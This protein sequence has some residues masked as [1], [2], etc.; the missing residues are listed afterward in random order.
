MAQPDVKIRLTADDKTRAAFASANSNLQ[1]L[2][3]GAA[4]LTSTFGA[5]GLA[6]SVG[7]LAAFAKSGIDAADALNDMSQRLGVSVKDL[8]S[9]KLIAEQSGTSLESVGTGIARLSKSIGEAEGGNKK[10]AQALQQLGITAR[11]PKE[12]FFQL[13]DAVQ[14]TEDPN[15]RAALLSAVLGKSY[16]ELV[17][18][19]NQGSD[20]LRESA[21]QSET[22]SEAMARLAP[23]A[24][25][26]NDELER[27]KTEGA[28]A[29]AVLLERIVPGLSDTAEA[30]RKLLDEDK[31]IQALVRAFAGLGKLPFDALIGN[32]FKIAETAP[33]R[34]KELRAELNDLQ[35]DLKSA[36]PG[37]D[38]SSVVMR[39]LFGT[40]EE[41]QREIAIKKNQIEALEKFGEQVYKPKAADKPA[42]GV[43]NTDFSN[44]FAGKTKA[45]AKLDEI[46]PFSSQ[47]LAAMKAEAAERQKIS[48]F[49]IGQ[50]E[51]ENDAIFKQSDALVEAQR[52]LVDMIDPSAKLVRQLTELDK[53]DGVLDPELLAAARLEINGQIDALNDMAPAID[54]NNDMARELGLTFE[55]AFENAI[56][57]GKK[58]SDVLKGLAQ[59]ILRIIARKA[60]TEPLGNAVGDWASGL[61]KSAN[62]NVFSNAPA[63][64]A[65]SGTVQTS[66][67]IF[68]FANGGVPNWGIGAEAGAE[69]ILPLKRG[70]DGKLGVSADGGGGSVVMHNYYTIDARGAD[71]GVEQRIRRAMDQAVEIA[72]SQVQNL[73]QR[74]QLRLT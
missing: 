66:P 39:K 31:G 36:Q 45:A 32:P 9:F 3:S 43:G 14:K 30:V 11:D 35:G 47:R 26:F 2:Q 51:A 4:K 63:L 53:F 10:L 61:F 74:G 17:P 6:V 7:G 54:K 49:Y 64:S 40:P 29:A 73:N 15:K 20:A 28:G 62:G 70:R 19:L 57:G 8:A 12:A 27:L 55:S 71:A 25:K 16:G 1:K 69:A 38:K 5:L 34:I 58:F 50:I 21:R 23:N 68:P 24:D 42:V 72:V 22:F 59:D 46:D 60:I 48:D 33:A 65:Y 41:I 13:A 56:V 37:G 44:A 67:F 52:G 18:L